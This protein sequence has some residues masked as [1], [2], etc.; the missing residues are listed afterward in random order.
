MLSAPCGNSLL[1]GRSGLQKPG[2]G[3]GDLF[4]GGDAVGSARRL[5]DDTG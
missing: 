1:P 5:I 2:S 4:R 3:L